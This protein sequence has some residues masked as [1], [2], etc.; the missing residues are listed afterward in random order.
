MYAGFS[1]GTLPAQMLLQN[2]P[3]ARGAVLL[4]GC[5]PPSEFDR[6]WPQDVPVQIHMMDAD[7]WLAPPNLDLGAAR[8]LDATVE[9]TELFLYPGDRHLFTDR[10]LAEYW[11][12]RA[13]HW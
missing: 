7:P 9:R 13:R 10:S 8:E 6:P 1:L 12:T 5:I 11:T 3:G 2:R 4:H